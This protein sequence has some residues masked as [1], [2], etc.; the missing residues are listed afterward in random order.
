MWNDNFFS[1]AT[2]DNIETNNEPILLEL[3][4]TLC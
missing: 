3:F 2:T 1:E 4:E